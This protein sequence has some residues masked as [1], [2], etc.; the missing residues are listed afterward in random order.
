MVDPGSR[1]ADAAG[2]RIDEVQ[3]LPTDLRFVL[4]RV[5]GAWEGPQPEGLRAP[6][7]V[8]DGDGGEQRLDPLPETSDAAARA[9]SSS[10]ARPFRAAFSV[11]DALAPR[12]EEPVELDLG[13]LTV[14]LPA[15]AVPGDDPEGEDAGGTVV[16]PEVL[17][18]RRAR[19]A[20]RSEE[21]YLERA[22]AA[23]LA[24]A[25]LEGELGRL[26][27]LLAAAREE[28]GELE[29]RLAAA[30]A[31]REE[32]EGRAAAGERDARAAAE[33]RRELDARERDLEARAHA[34]TVAERDVAAARSAL[35]GALARARDLRFELQ[36][37]R[38]EIADGQRTLERREADLEGAL[39]EER[40]RARSA[41]ARIGELE[42]ALATSEQSGPHPRARR[43]TRR[44]PSPW[45]RAALPALARTDVYAAGRLALGLLPGQGLA[46]SESLDYELEVPGLGRHWVTVR[47]GGG[48]LIE[49]PGSGKPRASFR[50][51]ST[52]A[53][54]VEL[55][56]AG[57]AARPAG[58]RATRTLRRRRALRRLPPVPLALAPLARAGVLLDPGLLY[59]ALAERIEPEWTRGQ[60]FTVRLDV[61]GRRG[62]TWLLAAADGKR[63]AVRRAQ[64]DARAAAI[65]AGHA[66]LQ[67]LLDGQAP[68]AGDKPAMRGDAAVI[69]R[70]AEWADRARNE[71][72]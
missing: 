10:E 48:E 30:T 12:L 59:R 34:V 33:L 31:E 54:L 14:R 3:V 4:L 32:L 46:I 9:A 71:R 72:N 56:I 38:D 5:A 42:R 35:A 60:R 37:L 66:T 22:G 2:L 27:L 61:P 65:E 69:A 28:H 16:D 43:A 7:L 19:R 67:H 24:A 52:A 70:L 44:A 17:A 23:Q 29:R 49:S 26:E 50:I 53:G 45:L 18:E 8:L 62:G 20:E 13:A 39:E 40:A 51:V 57:G 63:L 58:V 41:E 68:P 11:P 1:P 6:V 64:A 25:R 21:A 55:A 15:P 47:P 36:A